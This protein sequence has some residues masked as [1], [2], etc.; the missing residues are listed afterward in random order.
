MNSRR[1][2]MSPLEGS[3]VV[4]PLLTTEEAAELLGLSEQALKLHRMTGRGVPF[5]RL[6]RSVRYNRRDIDDYVLGNTI[7]P[8]SKDFR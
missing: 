3:A 1:D 8:S 5:V 2:R 6:G 7:R 4:G